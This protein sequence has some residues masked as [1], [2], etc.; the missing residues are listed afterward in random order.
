MERHTI[1]F[2]NQV[3]FETGAFPDPPSLTEVTAIY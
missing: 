2:R 3:G 1:E